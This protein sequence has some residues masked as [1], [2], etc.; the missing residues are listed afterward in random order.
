MKT[1][2]SYHGNNWIYTS[3]Q[4]RRNIHLRTMQRISTSPTYYCITLSKIIT[5]KSITKIPN[6]NESSSRGIQH[7]YDEYLLQSNWN[8]LKNL[9]F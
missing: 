7:T 3:Y 4:T 6:H 8:Y 5:V 9:T 2:Y 1:S